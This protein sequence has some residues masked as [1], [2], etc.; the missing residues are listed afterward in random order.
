[1]EIE[2]LVRFR[3]DKALSALAAVAGGE[4]LTCRR[5]PV[6]Q[7]RDRGLQL[8]ST[9]LA[10]G[11]VFFLTKYDLAMLRITD[12]MNRTPLLLSIPIGQGDLVERCF[13]STRA[14]PWSY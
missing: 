6:N 7:T 11:I 1:M 8:E 10:D 14:K 12:G 13:A 3:T 2:D 4:V 5:A 9:E